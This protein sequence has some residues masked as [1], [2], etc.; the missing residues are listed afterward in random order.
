[1]FVELLTPSPHRTTERKEARLVPIVKVVCVYVGRRQ[2]VGIPSAAI[3]YHDWESILLALI[4]K[5]FLV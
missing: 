1:M 2:R 3:G 4:Y 5:F